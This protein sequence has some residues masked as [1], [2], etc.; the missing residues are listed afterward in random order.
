MRGR[1]KK[2]SIVVTRAN[3][4]QIRMAE[5]FFNELCEHAEAKKMSV[6]EYIRFSA[7]NYIN[8][9]GGQYEKK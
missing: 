7:N 5:D 9:L 3:V 4:I 1:P 8:F 2:D 6:A